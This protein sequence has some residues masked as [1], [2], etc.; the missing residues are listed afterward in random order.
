MYTLVIKLP[1]GFIRQQCSSFEM[2]DMYYNLLSDKWDKLIEDSEGRII[3][4]KKGE[5]YV[6]V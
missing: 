4:N 3:C 5:E 1:Y 2:A 6:A